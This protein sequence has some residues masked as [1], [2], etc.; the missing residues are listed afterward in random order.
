[1]PAMY[2]VYIMAIVTIF[3]STICFNL[4]CIQ[5]DSLHRARRERSY[6]YRG[7]HKIGPNVA[8][9]RTKNIYSVDKCES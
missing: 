4:I 8:T 1:M 9:Y 6:I 3:C 7:L 2:V 5:V